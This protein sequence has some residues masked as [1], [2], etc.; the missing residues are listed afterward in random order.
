MTEET[1]VTLKKIYEP[2]PKD[3]LSGRNKEAYN[4]G[5]F[6]DEPIIESLGE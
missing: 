5:M 4:H 2:T 1:Q 6:V 3:I